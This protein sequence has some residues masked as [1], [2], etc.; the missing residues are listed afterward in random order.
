MHVFCEY[1]WSLLF[2]CKCNV[3][4]AHSFVITQITYACKRQVLLMAFC[5]K[6][7]RKKRGVG[8][9]VLGVVGT[10]VVRAM[11]WTVSTDKIQLYL[12]L[13]T[14]ICRE[15]HFVICKKKI[16]LYESEMW[17]EDPLSGKTD[18]A[19]QTGVSCGI[20]FL[21]S[22]VWFTRLLVMMWSLF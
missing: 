5:L 17:S 19:A 4:F 8:Y 10:G 7:K 16:V 13:H 3:H 1:Q 9:F 6:K 18:R 22:S 14:V 11:Q 20:N 2:L 12:G 15:S 21:F